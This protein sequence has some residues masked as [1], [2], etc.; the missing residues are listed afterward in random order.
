V[1]RSRRPHAVLTRHFLRTFLENDLISPDADRAQLLAIVGAGIVSLTTFLSLFG[2]F[3]YAS[4]GLTPGQAALSALNDRSSWLALSMVLTA[5]VAATQWDALA[6]DT[7]DTTILEPLPLRTS[8]IRRAKIAAVGML[9]AGVAILVNAVPSAVFPW[10]LVF[11]Q[12]VTVAGMFTLNLAHAAFS[13]AAAAFGYVSVLAL[14]E[15]LAGILGPRWFVRISPWVQG[16]LVVTFGSALLLL[17]PSGTRITEGGLN[18]WRALSPPMWFVGAYEVAVGNIVAEAPRGRMTPRQRRVDA[19]ATAVYRAHRGHFETLARRAAIAFGTLSLLMAALYAFNTRRLPAL[20][21]APPAA[22]RRRWRVAGWVTKTLIVRDPTARAGFYFALAAMWRSTTHRLTL[23]CAGAAGVAMSVIA[24]SSV[25]LEAARGGSIPARLFMVQPLLYGA[26]LVAFR[27]MV[28][29]PAELRANWGF[30]LAWRENERAFL[31]GARRAAVAGL[32]LPALAV[33]LPL[34]AYV[35]GPQLALLHAAMGFAGA[36]VFLEALMAGY[37]KVPFTCTYLP[38]GRI[39]AFGIIFI[40]VFVMG[41]SAYA[42]MERE[43]VLGDGL[44]TLIITL[45]VMFTILRVRSITR[46]RL[47]NVEFDEAPASLQRL[48]LHT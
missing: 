46:S 10:M 8:T 35:L 12:P 42:R 32:V 7:R 45:G 11:Q 48:G 33:L 43:A 39:K 34:F 41:A 24:L 47:P 37:E 9:G 27:H 26:L 2:S 17:P 19:A 6:V 13:T 20:T 15:T 29:V 18:G 23:A 30:Q 28:R 4:L 25:D 21:I 40:V 38:D 31:A 14:R 5:L 1:V 22:R 3:R 44:S 16:G 36:L